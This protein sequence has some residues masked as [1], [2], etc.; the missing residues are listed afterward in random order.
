MAES[1]VSSSLLVSEVTRV[2][3]WV[4]TAVSCSPIE[5]RTYTFDAESEKEL[6]E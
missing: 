2:P 6:S 4:Y 1:I 5:T 3:V